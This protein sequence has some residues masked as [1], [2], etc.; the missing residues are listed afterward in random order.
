M[1]KA[2][3]IDLVAESPEAHGVFEAYT[4]TVTT[5]FAEV[6]SVT[7]SEFY[8]AKENGIEPT[9]VFR[10]T[11]YADYH[12]EKIAIM[13]SKRYRI[14]RSYVTGQSIELTVEEATN[15]RT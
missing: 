1:L 8:R 15:D 10:L 7:R 6:R 14:V 5:V 2:T 12:G 11:D 9:Y 3:T 4:P 13:E